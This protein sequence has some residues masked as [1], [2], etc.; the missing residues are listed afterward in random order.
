MHLNAARFL[1][2]EHP[3]PAEDLLIRFLDRDRTNRA[4]AAN[5][6][7][8]YAMDILGLTGPL[9]S[10]SSRSEADRQRLA[11]R[12]QTELNAST[13]ALVLTGAG[14]ALPNLFTRTLFARGPNTDH[15]PFELSS[16]LKSKARE[17]DPQDPELAGPMPLIREFEEFWRASPMEGQH[18]PA[19]VSLSPSS[20][21]RI[22]GAVQATKL[23]HKREPVYPEQARAA[24]IQ[25]VVRLNVVIGTDGAI[26]NATLVAGHPLLVPAALE[27]VRG[28]RYHPTLLNGAPVKVVTE[29]EVPFLLAP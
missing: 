22:G 27:A 19:A 11:T 3:E 4:I 8:C 23:I 12:A 6:G 5:L 10:F 16:K 26:E 17:L 29:V 24:R 7:F 13:N 18:A 9:G 15:T 14:T 28:Y 1:Y 20:G 21:I 2:V 25:G